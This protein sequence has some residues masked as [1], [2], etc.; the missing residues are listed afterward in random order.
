MIPGSLT[1][2]QGYSQ[3]YTAAGQQ[4]TGSSCSMLH[5]TCTGGHGTL[6]AVQALIHL[7]WDTLGCEE[8]H[9]D[10]RAHLREAG[11]LSD[12]SAD[13]APR[14]VRNGGTDESFSLQGRL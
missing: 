7:S 10:V 11:L 3:A 4:L 6:D 8:H 9:G 12:G 14:G 2:L 1:N 13:Y 5:S